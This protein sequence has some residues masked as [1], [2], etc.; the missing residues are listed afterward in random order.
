M[1]LL[2][3]SR[4]AFTKVDTPGPSRRRAARPVKGNEQT[5]ELEEETA[6]GSGGAD[7]RHVAHREGGAAPQS[8]RGPA[9]PRRDNSPA[10]AAILVLISLN[11]VNDAGT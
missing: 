5:S 10:V 1:P 7:S 4:L 11:L 9:P 8:R 2:C 6:P 3:L